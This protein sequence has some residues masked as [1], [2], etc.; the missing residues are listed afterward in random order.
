MNLKEASTKKER[1]Q[2]ALGYIDSGNRVGPLVYLE[3]VLQLGYRDRDINFN[4]M[5]AFDTFAGLVKTL[6]VI[7]LTYWIYSAGGVPDPN[8]VQESKRFHVI[9][10]SPDHF[11]VWFPAEDVY[12]DPQ[13]A[14]Q[15][16]AIAAA[17]MEPKR[18]LTKG[19]S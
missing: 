13:H 16:M 3:T 10:R 14:H 18:N 9:E 2:E 5:V 7:T 8:S 4:D 11:K 19:E 12:I 1:W 17:A 15:T 6:G